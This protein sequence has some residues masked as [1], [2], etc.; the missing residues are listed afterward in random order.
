M[1]IDQFNYAEYIQKRIKEI[2]DLDERRFAK[3]ILLE[4]IERLFAWTENKYNTLQQRIQNELAVPWENF[5]IY[6]TVI[7]RS[8]YDPIHK[9]WFPMCEEDMIDQSRQTCPVIYLMAEDELCQEFVLQETVTGVERESGREICFKIKAVEKYQRNIEKLYQLFLSN[10]LPWQTVHTGHIERF[11]E[12]VPMEECSENEILWQWGKWETYVKT[13]MVPL[14]NIRKV[15]LHS[16]EFRMPCVDKAVYEH[17]FYLEDES[18]VSDGYLVETEEE[19]L[20]VRCEA[21]KILLKTEKDTMDKAYLYRVC[22]KNE[23]DSHGYQ[24]AV[25][26]NQRR[27]SFSARYLNQVG[28]FIQTPM[29]LVRKIGELSGENGIEVIKYEIAGEVKENAF[30]GDMNH[31]A[32][33]SVFSYDKRK[34]LLF[35]FKRDG[36]HEDYLLKAHVRYILSQLQIEFMEY[37]CMGIFV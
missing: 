34:I 28:N 31:F 23:A 20:S 22:Q 33:S 14:W 24:Y 12:L 35:H 36:Y 8:D 17:I 30:C 1:D 18:T 37:R 10:H 5:S 19:I 26:T 16:R 3:M 2:D 21:D 32:G 9:F 27:N 11:F 6:T 15:E 7:D 4:N 29:E 13:E 25:L